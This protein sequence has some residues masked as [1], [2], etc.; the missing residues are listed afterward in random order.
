[1]K[2]W[3]GDL[4]GY[5]SDA[6]AVEHEMTP[7]YFRAFAKRGWLVTEGS[8][9]G[10]QAGEHPGWF[11]VALWAPHPQGTRKCGYYAALRLIYREEALAVAEMYA[12]Y[13]GDDKSECIKN[14]FAAEDYAKGW[15]F[16]E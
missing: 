7:R 16:H 5:G 15:G 9:V 14:R 11:E 4:R 10:W 2:D 6:I 8:T 12:F 13:D 3:M 1:M